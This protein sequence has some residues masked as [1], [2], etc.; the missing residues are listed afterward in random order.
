MIQLNLSEEPRFIQPYLL[1][2]YPIP[3]CLA[4]VNPRTIEGKEWWDSTRSKAYKQNN[5]CCF[6]CG[7]PSFES[8]TPLEAH[9]YYHF[10]FEKLH[11]TLTRVVALCVWCHRF[12]HCFRTARL[13]YRGNLKPSEVRKQFKS[14]IDLLLENDLKPNYAQVKLAVGFTLYLTEYINLWRKMCKDTT[15]RYEL[16]RLTDPNWKL[17]YKGKLYPEEV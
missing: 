6:A 17:Y 16:L 13:M 1:R 8:D 14:R 4:G 5:Y 2:H 10:D 3:S 9:E 11:L 12:I 7:A 15:A